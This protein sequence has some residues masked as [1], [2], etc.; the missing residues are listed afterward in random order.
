M[1]IMALVMRNT[2][3]EDNNVQ[4]E[5][6]RWVRWGGLPGWYTGAR[7]YVGNKNFSRLIQEKDYPEPGCWKHVEVE[8]DAVAEWPDNSSK[9]S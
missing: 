9:E 4:I 7:L 8:V 2:I 3:D 6:G 5:F 1:K